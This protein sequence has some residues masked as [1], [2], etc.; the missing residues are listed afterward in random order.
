MGMRESIIT[1]TSSEAS[2]LRTVDITTAEF[3]DFLR[4]TRSD[5]H[6]RPWTLNEWYK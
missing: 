4:Y 2:I 5:S 6:N 3:K 1:P